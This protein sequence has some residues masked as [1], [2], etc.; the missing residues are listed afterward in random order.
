[1][2]PHRR[3]IRVLALVLAA[4]LLLGT[5]VGAIAVLGAPARAD[6]SSDSAGDGSPTG[7]RPL[8]LLGTSGLQW[9]DLDPE[10]TPVLWA[11]AQDGAIGSLVVRNQR[12]TT[13]P[14]EGWLAVSS[15]SRSVD[16]PADERVTEIGGQRCRQLVEP[17]PATADGVGSPVPGWADYATAAGDS[18]YAARIGL[19]GDEIA[20][21]GLRAS[22]VGPGAA[23]ALATADGAV[24][25]RAIP[26]PA[27]PADLEDLVAE[28]V[29]SQDVVV[30]DL[31]SV[32][33]WVAPR[34][35]DGSVD[36]SVVA[37]DPDEHRAAQVAAIESAAAAALAGVAAALDADP[38]GAGRT[39]TADPL[40]VVASLG[41]SGRTPALQVL[42][43]RSA[44]T[45]TLPGTLTTSSTR[46]HGYVLSTDLLP[47]FLDTLGLEVRA[48]SGAVLVGAPPRVVVGDATPEAGDARIAGLVDDN[49]HAQA[50][51]PILAPFYLLLVI[52]NVVLYALVALGLTRPA[53]TRLGALLGRWLHVD[54]GDEPLSIIRP[55]ILRGV[56]TVSVALA[57]VPVATLLTNLLP[58]WRF[59]PPALG[60]ALYSAV[61]VAL[62]TALALAGPW[63]DGI[64]APLGIVSGLT[65]LVIGLDV[66]TGATLQLSAVMGVPVL[67]AGR[68]YGFNNTAFAL[69]T[70][71]C[72]LLVVAVTNPL[73]RAGRR[74]LAALVVAAVG[75]V[76]TVLDGA[77]SIGADFGGP[78]AIVPAFA[79]LTLMALG[80]RLTWRRVATVLL[81]GAVA[82]GGFAFLDY[83]RPPASRSHLG[84]F[85]ETLLDGGA[86]DV[87]LRKLEANLRILANNRP[88]TILA[89]AGVLLVVF[90]L[91]RPVSKALTEPGG[92]R[93]GW[94]SG[95]APISQMGDV[96]PMLRPGLVALAVAMGIGFAV[97]DSGIAIPAYGVAL[98]VPLLLAACASWMLTRTEVMV[99]APPAA[100]ATPT[101]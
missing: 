18:S 69:F 94:L 15:G 84:R 80:V 65:A 55:R 93:F 2:Q 20:A 70:T 76:A 51:R 42:L 61:F 100:P 35:E 50:Q 27:D 85:V 91:A 89:L 73:V 46:Q 30:V 47:W 62:I 23:I 96:T 44:G 45:S 60:L 74:R 34:L 53:T 29:A 37:P 72:I 4:A 75:L 3:S 71:A 67:V 58:W 48:A 36:P 32:Q 16:L 63:R 7:A 66:V 26:R 101:G 59:S 38:A 13:C 79:L 31:G 22:A 56:R 88:L 9:E 21:D 39:L 97:N 25:G 68:F 95:G 81:A 43:A 33:D 49:T 14:A 77:P 87:V 5:V 64:L 83:L 52:A 92:G 82:V 41:D 12:T 8:V 57:S 1:M 19:L 98:A 24:A 90:V 40:V 11:A 28:L 99:V 78:P 86:W 17:D 6:E 10:L 54:G